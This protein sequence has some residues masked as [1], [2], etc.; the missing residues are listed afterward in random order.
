MIALDVTAGDRLA[1][2]LARAADL[3]L[4]PAAGS[5]TVCILE[6]V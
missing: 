5:P 6:R 2:S 3:L 1:P 4:R